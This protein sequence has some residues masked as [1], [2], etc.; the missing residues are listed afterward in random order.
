MNNLLIMKNREIYL[1]NIRFIFVKY[2][3]IIK[4]IEYKIYIKNNK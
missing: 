4:K 2:F 1:K 3:E